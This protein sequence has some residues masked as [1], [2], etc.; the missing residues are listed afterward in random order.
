MN[1]IWQCTCRLYGTQSRSGT[2]TFKDF[3]VR[4]AEQTQIT[5]VL[6]RR[7]ICVQAILQ[8]YS[9]FAGDCRAAWD[10]AD[11]GFYSHVL[12]FEELNLRLWIIL[13][14]VMLGKL[15]NSWCDNLHLKRSYEYELHQSD[16]CAFL[17]RVDCRCRKSG[18]FLFGSIFKSL[19][20][21][22]TG[23]VNF[24]QS[25]FFSPAEKGSRFSTACKNLPVG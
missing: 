14:N 8:V 17:S 7:R 25:W 19:L 22:G 5:K 12:Y 16:A 21:C 3:L 4:P 2:Y 24:D 18:L 20:L 11:Q 13:E 9:Q 1:S 15:A 6:K 10:P 23:N